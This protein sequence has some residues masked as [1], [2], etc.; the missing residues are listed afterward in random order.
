MA[1]P[2]AAGETVQHIQHVDYQSKRQFR[3]Y[4]VMVIFAMGLGSISMGYSASIIGTTLA[5]PSFLEYFDLETR[6]NG[7]SLI[8]SMNGL[9]Q[10]GAFFGALAISFIGDRFGR[11]AAIILPAILIVISGAMLAG[12]VHIAMFFVFRF[13]SGFGSFMLLGSIPLWMTEIVPP[14]N[15][16]SLVDIHS[17]CLLLGYALAAWTGVGFSR[18]KTISAWRGP[19]AIQCLPA[20]LVLSCMYWLPESPR[21]LIQKGKHEQARKVLVRLHGEEEGAIEFN[22]IN[23]RV[24]ADAILPNTWISLVKKSSYRKRTLFA[25]GL[26][27]GIQFTGVLVINNYSSIIYKNLGCTSGTIL[28]YSAGLNT[29]AWGCGIIALFII[30]FFPRNR[31]VGVGAFLTTSCLTVEAALVACHPV[32]D[33][34]NTTALQAAAAMTFCYMAFAQLLLDGTQYVYYAEIFPNHLRSKGMSIGIGA[35]SLMNVMWLQAA[36]TAFANIGWKFYLCFIIP[37]YAFALFCFFFYP[38]TRGLA[39]EEIAALFGD[40][41]EVVLGNSDTFG[42]VTPNNMK[43]AQYLSSTVEHLEGV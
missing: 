29:L 31:L 34:S 43:E 20:V 42:D 17:T 21:Y 11:K 35:I 23:T 40:K 28:F 30:D 12:S 6:S 14:K 36:P 27:C 13:L 39:L 19:L 4:N 15:R 8:S 33:S 1:K 24:T 10:A 37:A 38:D 9:F 32:G 41:N 16:G 3:T 22:Q 2:N 5:Q 26:A 18:Y 7:T 25:V